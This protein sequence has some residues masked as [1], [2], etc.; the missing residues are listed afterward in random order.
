MFIYENRSDFYVFILTWNLTNF[1]YWFCKI[2]AETLGFSAC[3]SMSIET[4]NL[5]HSDFDGF[6]DDLHYGLIDLTS[7]SRIMFKGSGKSGT[8]E[9]PRFWRKKA[10]ILSPPILAVGLAHMAFIILRYILSISVFWD[11]HHEK[12]LIL[13]N[14][15]YAPIEMMMWFLLFILLIWCITFIHLFILNSS[16]IPGIN[17]SWL[18]GM[19]GLIS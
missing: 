1:V 18:W 2:L 17:P 14:I 7:S 11:V 15:F 5:S 8:H 12:M 3:N 19:I 16:C 10:F 4:I 9:C 13:S 6:D